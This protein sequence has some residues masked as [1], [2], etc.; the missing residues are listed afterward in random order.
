M[1]SLLPLVALCAWSSV[2]L[3]AD[4]LDITFSGSLSG[5]G[6]FSTDGTCTLCM[7]GSGLL[8]LTINIGP[9]GGTSAFD[10][11]DDAFTTTHTLYQRPDNNL[12][13]VAT[14]SETGNIL[15]MELHIWN[16]FRAG[17]S[18]GLGT[19]SVT[20]V[21]APEPSSLFLLMTTVPLV[22]LLWRHRRHRG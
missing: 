2:L 11:S 14:N 18:I 16:L 8:N 1:R 12:G 6:T 21:A 7:P 9:D 3:R 5:S 10:I 20:P 13:F 15:D 19:Y 17:Q 4:M 22:G